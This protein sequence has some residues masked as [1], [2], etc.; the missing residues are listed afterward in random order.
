VNQRL[1]LLPDELLL[2][3]PL[4]RVSERDVGAGDRSGTRAAVCLQHVAVDDDRVLPERFGVNDSTQRATD[5]TR[6]LVSTTTDLALDALAVVT[7][8]RRAPQHRIFRR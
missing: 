7:A 3:A 4:D 5:Q 2:P 8:V 1:R 6:D